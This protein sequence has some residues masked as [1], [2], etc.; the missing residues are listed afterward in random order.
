VSK[1]EAIVIA[2]LPTIMCLNIVDNF[3]GSG[4]L[5]R[6]LTYKRCWRMDKRGE[7]VIG[8]APRNLKIKRV[9][10]RIL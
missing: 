8:F 1:V 3:V 4:S 10:R 6:I 2:G 7:G 5:I 9:S